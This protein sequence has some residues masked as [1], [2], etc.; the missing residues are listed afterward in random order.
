MN[1]G[2][3]T[4][5]AYWKVA[6]LKHVLSAAKGG[7]AW[8]FIEPT[9]L[10]LAAKEV[11]AAVASGSPLGTQSLSEKAAKATLASCGLP[12]R[13]MLI[14]LLAAE[15]CGKL[16][17]WMVGGIEVFTDPQ[18][19][20]GI[21][22]N[23]GNPDKTGS[24]LWH[25]ATVMWGHLLTGGLPSGAKRICELG[26]G[27]GALGLAL[28]FGGLG[29]EVT[30]TDLP[31]ALPLLHL[32][33]CH[34]LERRREQRA[35]N[36]PSR[37]RTESCSQVGG[38]PRGPGGEHE[39]MSDAALPRVLPLLWGDD[40]ATAAVLSGASSSGAVDFDVILGS[41]ICY[42]T[43]SHV[44]LLHTLAALA[45]GSGRSR[46][47]SVILGVGDWMQ[48]GQQHSKYM[49]ETLLKTGSDLGWEWEVKRTITPG[50]S[51]LFG[52]E[53][54]VEP[55]WARQSEWVSDSSPMPVVILHGKPPLS[56][57]VA[58]QRHGETEGDGEALRDRPSAG[59][60]LG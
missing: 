37:L 4:P 22:T 11:A 16:G 8:R 27:C 7:S 52:A 12:M 46:T 48:P 24:S 51:G 38:C 10:E 32:N 55:Q 43:A 36:P 19:V 20:I 18:N 34:N 40:N 53:M 14:S 33:A 28:H 42:E 17:R 31:Q 29:Y 23:E 41:D 21:Q 59:R 2:Q 1:D 15:R 49:A 54:G 45:H 26:S 30:L 50:E 25:V 9:V 13:N 57:R 3:T 6:G 35:E 60:P 58:G 39:L 56:T 47:A 5:R 44:A